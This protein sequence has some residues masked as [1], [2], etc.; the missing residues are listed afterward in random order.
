MQELG[1]EV[2][3]VGVIGATGLQFPWVCIWTECVVG[4]IRLDHGIY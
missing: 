3:L 2:G 1:L 4:R